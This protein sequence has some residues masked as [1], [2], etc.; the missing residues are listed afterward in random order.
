MI[1]VEVLS[2]HREVA[3]RHRCGGAEIRI[4][5]GYDNDVILDDPYVAVQHLRLFRDEAGQIVAEDIGS[6]NGLFLDRGKERLP[7]IVVDGERPIRIG[8]TFLRVREAG[9]AVPRER[10][11][12][13]RRPIWPIAHIALLALP[14][15]GIA[16]FSLWFAD[17]GEP[18]LSYHLAP[19]LE[20]A[21]LA[22]LWGASGRS[23]R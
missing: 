16:A 5:R 14:T 4:G 8:H 6:A 10:L 20:L 11:A 23:S 18:R 7:R 3:S 1:W 12:Q 9:Y 13:R 15:L 21:A 22:L 2:R 17:T 19:L